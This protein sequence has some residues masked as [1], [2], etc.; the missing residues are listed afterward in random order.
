M[1]STDVATAGQPSTGYVAGD[2]IVDIGQQRVWRDGAELKLPALSLRFLDVLVR[3]A[4]NMVSFDALI[5]QV[6]SGSVVSPET[7][8]QRVK[9]LRDALG[10][11]PR[12]PRYVGAVRGRGYRLL[13]AACPF[14]AT[15][16]G[17]ATP[18][19]SSTSSDPRT[20]RWRLAAIGIGAAAARHL[21]RALALNPTDPDILGAA[22][23]LNEAL[24]RLETSV[25]LVEFLA[26]RDPMNAL[27]HSY[28]GNVYLN[29]GR[30]D[31]SIGSSRAAL[32]LSPAMIHVHGLIGDALF[33][34]GD[35]KA[36]LTEYENEPIEAGRLAGLSMT[37][38]ALADESESDA[39][40]D[41]LIE[42]HGDWANLIAVVYVYRG[43]NDR[44]FEW[45]HKAVAIRDASLAI[46]PT[47]VW[48]EQLHEDR[49]WAPFL[50]KIGK[51]PEQLA[52]IKFDFSVP[53]H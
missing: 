16:A 34:K 22:S 44:A 51:A 32:R 29:A 1:A 13:C 30:L 42:E 12:L 24:G 38:H 23:A 46:A 45:L 2:L 50:R 37:H 3:A 28:L 53:E 36:A 19:A 5:Q 26:S 27:L 14:N 9:L 41:E 7:V 25:P 43:E 4:P 17:Q 18:P 31:E 35:Y 40:L 6:W 20:M 49:R 48:L 47:S 11:D 52:A 21:E 8:T 33:L 10:D 39:A 15:I